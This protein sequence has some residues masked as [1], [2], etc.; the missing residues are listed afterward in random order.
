MKKP[1]WFSMVVLSVAAGS[2]AATRTWDGGAGDGLWGSATN[3]SDNA[4]PVAGDDAVFAGGATV[5]VNGGNQAFGAGANSLMFNS[6]AAVTINDS[7]AVKGSLAIDANTNAANL[8]INQQNTGAAV[9]NAK[10][11]FK[12]THPSADRFD[13]SKRHFEVRLGAGGLALNGAIRA[14][15]SFS[16][17]TL[18]AVNELWLGNVELAGNNIRFGTTANA[19][20]VR[21]QGACTGTG[22]GNS[23]GLGHGNIRLVPGCDI[24]ASVEKVV[25]AGGVAVTL[26]ASDVVSTELEATGAASFKL[27]AHGNKTTGELWLSSATTLSVDFSDAASNSLWFAD[28]SAAAW[29]SG[30]LLNLVGFEAGKDALRF[31]TDA[32]G[33]SAQQLAQITANGASGSFSLDGHGYL[34]L[35][36]IPSRPPN[37][38]IILTDDHGYTDLGIHG[39]DANVHT[40]TLDSL[41]AGGALMAYGYSTAPQCVPSRS[42]LMSGRIQNTFGTRQ[43]GDIWGKI[44]VPLDVPTIAER[45][46]ALGGYKTGMVGKWHLEIP[47]EVPTEDIPGTRADYLPGARG[48]QEYWNGAMSPYRATFDLAG[49]TLDPEQTIADPRN[50]VIVQGEAAQAFIE[51]NQNQP[52][53]LYFA[54]Y[55]PHWP[56]ISTTDDYYLDFPVLDYPNYGPEMDDIRRLGLGLV[57][58]V[59]DA[60]KGVVQKLRDLGLEEN[61]LILFAGDNGAPP[62]FFSEVGGAVTLDSWTGC[63]NLPLRGEKGSLW[64]GGMKVPMFAYWKNHILPGHVIDEPVWTLDFTATALKLAGG[65]LP[66]NFDGADILPRLTGQTNA[67]ARTQPLFWDWGQEIALRDGDW[68]IHRIGDR[69]SLFNLADDPNEL[70]DLKHV[71]PAKFAAMEAVLMAR[72]NALP[73]EGKSPLAETGDNLYVLGAPAGTP[74]DPRFLIPYTNAAPA[75]YPAPLQI[76]DDPFADADGDGTLDVEEDQA[77]RDPNDA[78]DLAFEFNTAGD[79]ERWAP[80][81]DAF[82]ISHAVTNGLLAGKVASSQGKFEFYD[83]HFAATNMANLLVRIK[84][85]QSTGLTFRWGHSVSNIF[86]AVRTISASYPAN[87]WSTVVVPVKGHAQWDGQTI[88]R[89]RINPANTLADFEIDWIRGS[90]GDYDGDLLP[91]TY[92]KSIGLDAANAADGNI[93]GDGDGLTRGQEY[94]WGTSDADAQSVFRPGI[95]ASGSNAVFSWPGVA[96]RY[97]TL[98][99]T[100]DLVDGLWSNVYSVGPLATNAVVEVPDAAGKAF[101]RLEGGLQ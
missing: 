42:G 94:I 40:P 85:P 47:V 30:A 54:P 25:L 12:N 20:V 76:V 60:V 4:L 84:S 14:E 62:K 98:W 56:R 82:L 9:V 13:I 53:F 49:N 27:G 83:F 77:G 34:M 43:N 64:E 97:Y 50:R 52:F 51:R 68:K 100:E 19:G 61:T 24:Q 79:Y 73:P 57:W 67:I 70:Y 65:T 17:R 93:D 22:T 2:F 33:L 37:I 29:N 11:V 41:A 96:G 10:L 75:A 72:Y 59:D 101:Y 78:S 86:S 99:R 3:W 90:Q 35:D 88:T 6:T 80:I 5:D 26:D 18:S 32:G 28:S 46:V 63:E 16:L 8:T 81:A 7:A 38:I 44:P 45:L 87:A 55:G 21:L 15:T 39:I 1:V 74:V 95:A 71:Y 48:F 92:E 31:G 69:K 91:D 58:A 66:P 89:M 23:I 36:S